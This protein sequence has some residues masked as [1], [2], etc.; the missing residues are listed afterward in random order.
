MVQNSKNISSLLVQGST[1]YE[2]EIRAYERADLKSP[3]Y[4][5]P[6]IFTG[7]SSIRMWSNLDAAFPNLTTLNRGFGGSTM[8]DLIHYF[9]RLIA[10]HNPK[11]VVVYE[12]DNDLADGRNVTEI[13]SDFR[14]FIE[15]MKAQLPS[16]DFAFVSVKPSPSRIDL[17]PQMI[18]LDQSIKQLASKEGG[19]LFRCLYPHAG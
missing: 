2:F 16:S 9:D 8:Q 15:R 12:G 6:V 3:P 10:V 7:S 18:E 4:Q 1:L 11:L 5:Q 13:T 14:T 17:I 19:Q